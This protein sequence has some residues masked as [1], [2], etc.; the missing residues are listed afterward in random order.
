MPPME[1]ILNESTP[2]LEL[3]QHSQHSHSSF[4]LSSTLL[5]PQSP[6]P[7][8]LP[9][10]PTLPIGFEG[11]GMMEMVE[12]EASGGSIS[13]LSP[14]L[15]SIVSPNFL[16]TNETSYRVF[17][18]NPADMIDPWHSNADFMTIILTHAITFI[19]GVIGNSVVIAT[20]AKGGKIRSPTATFLV[21]LA[22]ADLL[23]LI[24]FMPLETLEY[25]VITWDQHGHICKLSSFVELLSGMS[26]ILNLVAVSVER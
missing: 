24:I 7:I 23:L 20:W 2:F 1:A 19:V 14:S 3:S 6:P 10:P 18:A 17:I 11:G 26:S 22:C 25:F 13:S 5:P 12:A 21:S 9:L 15:N 16:Q 8:P 4:S